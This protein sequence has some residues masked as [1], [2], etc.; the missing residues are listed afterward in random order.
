VLVGGVSEFFGLSDLLVPQVEVQGSPDGSRQAEGRSDDWIKGKFVK[1]PIPMD[2]LGRVCQLPGKTLAT[3]MAIW[4]VAGLRRRKDGLKLTTETLG[5]FAVN[6]SAKSRALKAL[7][8]A[9]LIRVHGEPRK[10]PEVTILE[11]PAVAEK[12]E[13][14]AQGRRRWADVEAQIDPARRRA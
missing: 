1:G 5:L 11:A 13:G 8:K 10:N 14:V 9:G 6:R 4:F 12:K 3:A 7:V 2:W